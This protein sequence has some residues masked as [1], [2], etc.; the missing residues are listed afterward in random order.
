[1]ALPGMVADSLEAASPFENV[2]DKLLI[3]ATSIV[4]TDL[5][6]STNRW[7]ALTISQRQSG[8]STA[9]LHRRLRA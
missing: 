6:C 9:K 3:D 2:H 7:R 4:P 1:M 8:A 5:S